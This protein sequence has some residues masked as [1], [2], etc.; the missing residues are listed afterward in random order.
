MMNLVL[1]G[2]LNVKSFYKEFITG[3]SCSF[4]IAFSSRIRKKK[5]LL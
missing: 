4:V 3:E 2:T 5:D 1:P